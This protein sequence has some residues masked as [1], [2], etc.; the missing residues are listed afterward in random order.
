MP[1]LHGYLVT[2]ST[3]RL[4]HKF[5]LLDHRQKITTVEDFELSDFEGFISL[6]ELVSLPLT[7]LVCNPSYPEKISPH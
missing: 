4:L 1:G 5:Y 3:L 2:S 6:E 7:E